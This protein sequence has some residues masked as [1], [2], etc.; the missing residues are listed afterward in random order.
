MLVLALSILS[1]SLIYV[2]FKY[3]QLYNA[4]TFDA[5]VVNYITA[6]LLGFAII[7]IA[8]PEIAPGQLID[9][10]RNWMWIAGVE[11]MLFISTF[12]IMALT[13]QKLSVAASSVASKMSMVIPIIIFIV[14]NDN[15]NPSVL[16]V[17][18]ILLACVAVVLSTIKKDSN[19]D[20]RF[21]YLPLLLF[22]GSGTIDFLIGFAEQQY[23]HTSLEQQLFIPTIFAL[24]GSIGVV[25]LIIKYLKKK[26]RF[27]PMSIL[28][29]FI[30][31][32]IN[33]ASL[34][35]LIKALE[36]PQ[37]VRSSIFSINNM[38]I[39]AFSTLMAII[40][41]KERLSLTNVIGLALGIIS[42]AIIL[43]S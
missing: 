21:W 22:L 26:N 39:I 11:G 7:L 2:V 10:D 29:G 34:Y 20:N 33:Y 15:D 42:I 32:L 19:W 1:S 35:F 6:T 27:N 12:F 3:I 13:A 8:N 43:V 40:L 16:K 17:I 4:N 30:L 28:L 25:I 37:L 18:G 5:I 14:I 36:D 38:G 31:G 23:L 41:F 9:I 24:T